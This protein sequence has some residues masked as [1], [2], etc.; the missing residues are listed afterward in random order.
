MTCTTAY[1]MQ[2][3][4]NPCYPEILT[5]ADLYEG[6]PLQRRGLPRAGSPAW[7]KPCSS[8]SCIAAFGKFAAAA[9]AHFKG[10]NVIFECMNEP[11]GMGLDSSKVITALCLAAGAEIKAAGELFVGPATSGFAWSYLNESSE[12]DVHSV[13][14]WPYSAACPVHFSSWVCTFCQLFL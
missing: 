12:C 1:I 8:P 14:P 9:V 4:G 2:D 11:N 6:A 5:K 3:Y 10:H 13:S 7:N